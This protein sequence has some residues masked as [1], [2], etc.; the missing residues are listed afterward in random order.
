MHGEVRGRSLTGARIET[1][2]YSGSGSC[3]RTKSLPHGSADRNKEQ[4]R[5]IT[6]VAES[7]PHGSADRNA[8]S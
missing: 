1:N 5:E 2:T 3:A 7:L 8:K 6:G 4:E